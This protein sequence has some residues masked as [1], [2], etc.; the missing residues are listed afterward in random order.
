V[1]TGG[2]RSLVDHLAESLEVSLEEPVLAVEHG[3]GGVIVSTASRS[4]Q[5]DRVVVTVPIG[6]LRQGS[7][8]FTPALPRPLLDA[9]ERLRLSTVEK[10]VLRYQKRWWPE[11]LRRLVHITETHRFPVWMDLSVHVGAPTLVG[12]FNPALTSMPDDPGSRLDLARE[13]LATMLGGGPKPI[14]AMI[15][16][17]NEDPY[18]AGAY[19]YIPAGATAEQMRVFQ[20][21]EGPLLFA[22]EHTIPEYHGTV[23]AAFEFGRRSAS[24]VL[25]A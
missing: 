10:I 9:I 19:S 17:W 22:G 3:A 21:L 5:A 1:L 23:H 25:G 7:I 13:S 16:E 18:A 12:F 6:V 14:G 8:V 2:Y 11:D 4:I 20:Y 15:T 24:R